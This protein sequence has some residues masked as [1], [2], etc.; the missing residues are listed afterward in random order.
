M[1]RHRSYVALGAALACA[2]S[3]SGQAP[4]AYPGTLDEHPSIQYAERP[5]ADPV[6]RLKRALADGT[7]AISRDARTGYLRPVLAA[8][9]VPEESQLLVFSKTGVQ[10]DDTSP[11]NPRALYFNPSVVVGYIAGASVLE[12][13]AHDPQ[14]GVVFY[15]ID[16]T[17]PVPVITRPATCPVCHISANTLD[18]PGV[19][20]R[21]NIVDLE[22]NVMPELGSFVVN[23]T[24]PHTQRWG[25]WFVTSKTVAAPPYQLMGHLGNM[26]TRVHPSSGIGIISDM[27]SIEWLNSAPETRGYLSPFSDIASLMVFDHQSHA[28]NLLTR[29]NWEARVAAS[30][31]PV[32]VSTGAVHDLVGDLADYLL[33][34]GEVPPVVEVSPRPGFAEQLEARFPKDRQGR[35]LGQLDL[36]TRLAR[37]P[38]S[39]MVYTE[40]FDGLMPVVKEAVYRRMFD[41][42]SGND[43]QARYAHLSPADRRAVTEILRDTKA[44]IP[45]W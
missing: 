10:R 45:A 18:V 8:L 34:V 26:T 6:A 23:H 21:S 14:Q 13:A 38:C 24:T 42:L 29:L 17:A 31:G 40:A 39:Y 5:A 33:F 22:G 35:S 1:I 11:R 15:T 2:A 3:L 25:G 16:Q 20:D 44:D 36:A 19:I 9:G 41:I 12:L 4:P 37:Y 27:V 32:D 43:T 7:I 30:R 28:I